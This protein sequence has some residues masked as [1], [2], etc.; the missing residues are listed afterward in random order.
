MRGSMESRRHDGHDGKKNWNRRWTQMNAN[1][2]Y[3]RLSASI[4]GSK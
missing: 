2:I 1:K 4:G 3:L